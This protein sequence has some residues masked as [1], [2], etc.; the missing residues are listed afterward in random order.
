MNP[1]AAPTAA[2]AEIASASTIGSAMYFYDDTRSL[3][4]G[5]ILRVADDPDRTGGNF[6]KTPLRAVVLWL[7]IEIL[8][9]QASVVARIRFVRLGTYEIR[10]RYLAPRSP[11]YLMRSMASANRL[12]TSD[13]CVVGSL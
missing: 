2:V 13:R 1:A 9:N 4:G 11:T 8:I 3:E 7:T 6:P 10:T 5:V 12:F